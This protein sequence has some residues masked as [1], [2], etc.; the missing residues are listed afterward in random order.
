MEFL[1]S[2]MRAAHTEKNGPEGPFIVF[3]P[4]QRSCILALY[5]QITE[6][7]STVDQKGAISALYKVFEAF[8]FPPYSSESVSNTFW[9]PVIRFWASKFLGKDGN[10]IPIFHIPVLIAKVQFSFRLRGYYL[11]FKTAEVAPGVP[12]QIG[13]FSSVISKDGNWFQ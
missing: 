6:D 2:M 8:Y 13:G 4:H 11:A 9:E 5:D 1:W 3:S 7:K 12:I 10:Y